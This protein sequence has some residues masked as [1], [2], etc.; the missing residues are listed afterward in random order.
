MK[1]S[2][3]FIEKSFNKWFIIKEESLYKI[4]DIIEKRL[5]EISKENLEVN[6]SIKRENWFM[7]TTTDISQIIEEYN[8]E[9]TLIKR[10]M[11]FVDDAEHKDSD[12][13]IKIIFDDRI[14]TSI[15]IS[16]FNND[17]TNLLYS[18]LEE[19][20]FHA[21]LKLRKFSLKKKESIV[22]LVIMPIFLLITFLWIYSQQSK[23]KEIIANED[24]SV[25]LNYLIESRNDIYWIWPL[26]WKQMGIL[27][28]SI[29][30]IFWIVYLYEHFYPKNIFYI[31][32]QKN[33]Y[34][35]KK[36]QRKL[37]R[38]SIVISWLLVGLLVA[39]LS[40]LFLK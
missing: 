24:L 19:Y 35:Q 22:A 4:K 14:N 34:D 29:I 27:I 33:K 23:S 12:K 40:W 38:S 2:L 26:F 10:I 32:E 18:D 6:F 7:F 8:W 17:F 5:K 20:L 21:V 31:W 25:K 9:K 1:E 16:W 37:F 28:V 11:I 39:R 36:E 30:V 15:D 13:E 3:A